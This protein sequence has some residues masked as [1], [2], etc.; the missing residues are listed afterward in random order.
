M[1]PPFPI[2]G[3]SSDLGVGDK[4]T[5]V[6]RVEPLPPH[7][8]AREGEIYLACGTREWFDKEVKWRTKRLG[9]VA[10]TR[11]GRIVPGDFPV[12]VQAE[13]FYEGRML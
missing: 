10:Y 11:E 9:K 2:R 1:R 4:W 13:E 12:F 5:I 3:I 6:P 8:E 7:P